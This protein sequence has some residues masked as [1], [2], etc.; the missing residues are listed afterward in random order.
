MFPKHLIA[1][2]FCSG[3]LN[4]RGDI[5][6]IAFHAKEKYLLRYFSFFLKLFVSIGQ[7]DIQFSFIAF[8]AG[9]IMKVLF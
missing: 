5:N 4:K 2:R 1:V 7:K 8:D 3:L 9:K 6:G